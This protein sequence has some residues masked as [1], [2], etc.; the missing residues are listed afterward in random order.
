MDLRT[1]LL[2]QPT[3]GEFF[4]TSA[5]LRFG[6][7]AYITKNDK[8]RFAAKTSYGQLMDRA[9]KFASA[10]VEEG[11]RLG[12]IVAVMSNPAVEFSVV[13]NGTTMIG[14]VMGGIYVT[15]PSE[16][17]EY[18]LNHL[19][20]RVFVIENA[21][22]KGVPQLDKV[23]R[24][25]RK[26]LPNL[27]K[28]VVI[29]GFDPSADD[30]LVA[31]EDFA[32]NTNN[33]QQVSEMVYQLTPE[34]PAV[35]IYSSGT[36]GWPKGAILTHHNIMANIRQADSHTKMEE[37]RRYMD[38][39]P[40][41][42]V[43]GYMV[44][45][46]IEGL[47][48]TIYVSHRDTLAND[49]PMVSPHILAGVPKFYMALADRI[50][51]RVAAMGI[52]INNLQQF[53]KDLILRAA[54][55]HDCEI[56]ISGAAAIPDETV[57]FFKE[58]LNFR[59]DQAYG[60][61]ETSP[62]ITANSADKWKL[63]TVGTC[64]SGV[65]VKIF[66]NDLNELPAGAEGEIAISGENVFIGYYK[67]EDKTRHILKKIGG[68][69]WYFSGDIGFMDEEGFLKITDR[70]DDM[71]VPNSGENIS[72]TSVENKLTLHSRYIGYAVPYGT[73]RSYITSVIWSD[74]TKSDNILQDAKKAGIETTNIPEILSDPS[75]QLMLENDLRRVLEVG[76]FTNH[77]RPKGFVFLTQPTD[78]EVTGTL[79]ARKKGVRQ[80][81]KPYLDRL[82][83]EEL[84]L[85]VV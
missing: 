21:K 45:R 33:F 47:G 37:D 74:E 54:G 34:M 19:E 55:L 60:V 46:S 39:L 9:Y 35:I 42:H 23:L 62:G 26:N 73:H 5:S 20:A 79:K 70:K 28:I 84:F 49:L 61:T 83:N 12:D 30:R 8:G 57:V 80:K 82:Y 10:L 7:T 66:D 63:G 16:L 41:A 53:Q 29:G 52:D 44:R 38:F 76:E 56:A 78:E 59:I 67:D 4:L 68:K 14:A 85:I 43:F 32:N 48:A 65:E 36:E 58:K 50:R 2:S 17:V 22:I 11:Y 15:D 40:P 64:L 25:P 72:S 3:L 18:K 81:F 31:F 51:T 75:F 71:L 1:K 69:T 6:K 24:I 77:E 27:K 13:D